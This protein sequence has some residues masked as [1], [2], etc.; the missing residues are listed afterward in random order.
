MPFQ[1]GKPKTGGRKKGSLNKLTQTVQETLDRL[2]CNPIEGM[3]AIAE[4]GRNP[5][6]LRG[7]MYAELSQYV[8]PKRR[9][10]EH[11]G[12]GGSALITPEAFDE[13]LRRAGSDE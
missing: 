8:F 13:L 7:R 10:I 12:P 5:P 2:H 11:S 9:A 6:E 1:P 4:N 3:A